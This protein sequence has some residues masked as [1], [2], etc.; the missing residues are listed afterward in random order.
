MSA[1]GKLCPDVVRCLKKLR[2]KLESTQA[3]LNSPSI[4][5]CHHGFLHQIFYTLIVFN[6]L[7]SG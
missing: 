2:E 4:G 5:S 6:H 7:I 3:F 1:G